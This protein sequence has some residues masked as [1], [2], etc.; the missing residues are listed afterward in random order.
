MP[1]IACFEGELR[2]FS[3][4]F[5][6]NEN[7]YYLVIEAENNLKKFNQTIM[8]NLVNVESESNITLLPIM[9]N[10]KIVSDFPKKKKKS[11]E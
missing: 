3:L 10:K 7:N 4:K 11:K 6:Q 2:N 5:S 1:S 8:N 9:P